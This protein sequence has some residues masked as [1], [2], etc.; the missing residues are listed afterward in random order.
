MA[1]LDRAAMAA[2]V[3]A[4]E[5]MERAGAAVVRRL[6]QLIPQSGEV[7]VLCGPGNNGGDGLV[8]ARLLTQAGFTV[9]TVLV[10][11]PR[12]SRECLAQV[13][14][15]T[16]LP[17]A[18]QPHILSTSALSG[19][20]APAA[21]AEILPHP[22]HVSPHAIAQL[23]AKAAVVVDA[24]LGTGQRG[25]AHSTATPH[26]KPASAEP[27]PALIQLV[28]T[29]RRAH[30]RMKVVAVDIPT[31]VDGDTGAVGELHIE[32]DLTVT[33]ECCKR[34]MLQFPARSA[35]GRIE[36]AP[37]GITH[38]GPDAPEVEFRAVQGLV[39]LPVLPPRRPDL[40]KGD[41]GRVLVIGGSAAMPGAAVLAVLGALHAGA[42]V[43]TRVTR[44][45]WPQPSAPAE[46]MNLI[47]PGAA[48]TLEP[49]DLSA[50]LDACARA[51]VVVVGPGV[52]LAPAVAEF[53]RQFVEALRKSAGA[54]AGEA[55]LTTT[56]NP[57]GVVRPKLVV[58]ADALTCIA[59][60]SIQLAGLPVV[61]TPHPGE[62]QRLL[63]TDPAVDAADRFAVVR[64]LARRWGVVTLL[65]GAGTLVHDGSRG[66][67]V[68]RGTPYLATAG[69]GDVL[70]GVIAALLHRVATV[71]D[72]A[73]LGAYVHAC[74]GERAAA[75]SGGPILASEVAAAVS[76]EVGGLER[77]CGL[78]GGGV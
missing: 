64:A 10:A 33:F 54:A 28:A 73:V 48:A 21:L 75:R 17:G 12:Y 41:L 30:P 11:A 56:G 59:A 22:V 43:V 7:V 26:A 65:K 47:L 35:C 15:I 31:G 58:D 70:S 37:L 46:C 39:G 72:A 77:L 5:L 18:T 63:G 53:L 1:A 25:V 62:A 32:A 55:A 9:T 49:S 68:A 66:V 76:A 34:G 19:E 14:L 57:P 51:D 50:I 38:N 74:A 8:V 44:S 60:H 52:G 24:L 27:I 6:T 45:S 23:L 13:G 3:A 78:R 40:H 4:A 20:P 71:Q 69:S 16:Q 67:L 36:V 61:I 2:G 29:A 42:G